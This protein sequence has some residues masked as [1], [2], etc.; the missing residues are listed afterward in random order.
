[1]QY[2]L[3]SETRS[4]LLCPADSIGETVRETCVRLKNL[5]KLCRFSYFPMPHQTSLVGR[6]VVC[7]IIISTL[8]TN[9]SNIERNH[10][11]MTSLMNFLEEPTSEDK[12]QIS[13]RIPKFL[14]QLLD[15]D[16]KEYK[17]TALAFMAKY[18]NRTLKAC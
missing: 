11:V 7:E 15:S 2:D 13:T 1:M 10:Q 5:R 8:N 18:T 16:N 9:N 12:S 17:A 14:S 6:Q 4:V 3:H